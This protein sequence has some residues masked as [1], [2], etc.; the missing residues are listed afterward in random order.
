MAFHVARLKDAREDAERALALYRRLGDRAGESRALSLLGIAHT[1]ESRRLSLQLRSLAISEAIRD[2]YRQSQT[3]NNLSNVYRKLGL[4]RRACHHAEKSVDFD[5]RTGAVASLTY[6]ADSLA[7]AYLGLGNVDMAESLMIEGRDAAQ[8]AGDRPTVAFYDVVLGLVEIARDRAE[9]AERL[10]GEGVCVFRDVGARGLEAA[11]LAWQGAAR[12]ALGDVAGARDL[13]GE[14]VALLEAGFEPVEFQAQEIWWWRYCSL[15]AGD[16]LAGAQARADPPGQMPLLD[17]AWRALDQARQAMLDSVATLSDQG[18][19]RNYFNKVEINRLIIDA[20]LREAAERGLPPSALTDHLAGGTDLQSQM[21]RMLDIGVRINARREAGDLPRYV[22]DE[23]VEL[24]GADRA[25]LVLVGDNGERRLAAGTTA[26]AGILSGILASIPAELPTAEGPDP[27]RLQE[28]VPALDEVAGKRAPFLRHVPTGA[29]RLQQTSVLCVPLIAQGKLVG[30]IYCELVGVHGRFEEQDRDL[31][32]ILANQAAVA[33]ENADWAHTLEQRVQERTAALQAAYE[34]LDQRV[35]ELAL[36]N[37]IQQGLAAQLEAEEIIELVGDKLREIF[38]GQV[39]FVVQYDDEAQTLLCPY[40]VDG[41]GRRIRYE[42]VPLGR[43]LGSIVVQSRE[44]L[45][46]GSNQ[47]ALDLGGIMSEEDA[48]LEAEYQ[49]WIGVPVIVGDAVTGVIGLEDRPENAYDEGD[50]RLLSTL[51]AS[52]GVALENARL[53]DETNQLLEET[54]QRN[55]ELALINTIQQ[56]L[57]AQLEAEEIID[58][59]GDKLREIFPGQAAFVGQYDDA[60]KVLIWPYWVDGQGRRI[61]YEPVALGRG[62]GSI[63]VQSREPLIVGSIEEVIQL[64]GIMSEEDAAL[65]AEY[66]SW[67]GVPVIVGDAVTGVIGLEDRPENAYDEGDARLL[68]TLAASM[69]V[70]LENAR[71]FGETNQLLEETRQR[72]AEL[73]LI[74]TIQKGLAAQLDSE[75]IIHLVGDTLSEVFEGQA[76]IVVQ[77]DEA[78]E[79]FG[80]AYWVEK[81]GRKFRHEPFDLGSSLVSV[82]VQSRKPLILGSLEEALAL[83]AVID[84]DELE[85]EK[86]FQSWIGVPVIVGDAVIGVIALEDRPQDAYDEGDARLLSTLAASM[87]VA[88]QNARLFDETN[89]LLEETRRRAAELEVINSIGQGLVEQLDFRAIIELVG[90]KI[91]RIFAADATDIW[92]Y[93]SDTQEVRGAYNVEKGVR[94]YPPVMPYGR[95]LTSRVIESRLPVVGGTQ[96]ECIRLGAS[97]MPHPEHPDEEMNQSYL[98]V[99]ILVG[100]DVIGVVDVQSYREHAFDEAAVRLLSTIVANMGVALQNARLF[101]ETNRLLEETRRRASELV[102]VNRISR[103]SASELDQGALIELVGEQIRETFSADIAYV[104]LLERET[105]TIAFPYTY[106]EPIARIPLGAGV[107]SRILHTGEPL[108]INENLTDWTADQGLAHAGVPSLS[109]LGVPILVGSEAI[110]VVSVQSTTEAGRFDDDDVRLLGTIAANVG[111]AIQNSRLYQE[112]RRRAEEMAALAE[113]GSDIASTHELTPVLERVAAKARELLRVRDIA[114]ALL[115]PDGQT[116]A[117]AVALG[118]YADEKKAMTVRMG[119]GISGAVAQS[120]VA[121]IVNYPERDPR[122]VHIPG[123]PDREVDALMAAPLVSR[124]QVI[125]LVIAWRNRSDGLF[126]QADLDFLVSVARQAAIAIESARL[127]VEAERRADQMAAVA[128]LGR[129]ASATLDLGAVL[130]GVAS[131]IHELFEARDTVLRLLDP[132]GETLRTTVALGDYADQ[133]LDDTIQMGAGMTGAIAASGVAEV[134]EDVAS[135][136]RAMHVAGTPEVEEMPDTMMC[137]PLI[138]GSGTVGVLSLYRARAE[139][140]FTQVDL[141]FLVALARQVAIAIENAR[142]F[143]E[144]RRERHYSESIVFHS[145]VAITTADRNGTVLSWNPA[146]QRLFGHTAEEAIGRNLDVMVTTPEL[147]AE[148][149]SITRRTVAGERIHA[150]TQR[151]RKDGTP[152]DVEVYAVPADVHGAG[153]SYVAIYHDITELKRTEE[154]LRQ[155]KAAAEAA[156]QA[157]SAFLATMSH[158]IRTPMNAI[159]GMTSLL[160]DTVLTAEQEEYAETVRTSGDA[161]LTII[162]DILDFSKIEAGR[163]EL[164]SQPFD[165][166]DC[167]ESALGLVAARAAEKGLEIGCL[168]EGG[169]PPAIV[170]DDTRLRQVLVN[171]LSN[172]VKFTEEGEVVVTVSPGED[173]GRLREVHI[174]VRDTGIGIPADRMDRLFKSFSQVDVSTSRRYGGTGLGLA[175]SRRLCELMGGRIWVES[176]A[177]AGEAG[178]PAGGPGSVFHF[179]IRVPEA[180]AIERAYRQ[181][182]QGGLEGRRVLVVDDNATNRR[183]LALQ[184]RGWGM[185]A[186]STGSPGEALEWVRGGQEYAVA[187][188]D[189]QMPGMDGAELSTALRKLASGLPI[190]MVS[191]LGRRETGQ[192]GPEIDAFLVK[193]V[194]ASQLHDALVKI[195]AKSIA[196]AEQ[197]K[198]PPSAFDREMAQRLP[199]RILLAEDNVVNQKLALRLLQRLGYRSDVA[200]NGLETIEALR[201]QTYDVVLMDVQMPEMDGLDA[202][203]MICRDWP[204]ERRPHII[205]MTANVMAED[206]QACLEAGMDDYLAKPI[207]VEELVAAL[208]R[209]GGADQV[210]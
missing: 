27:I 166:R 91:N 138:A 64:G 42:P 143:E 133:F 62:L 68:S 198:P 29:A 81:G 171:L 121:E 113:I 76:A 102:T 8:R 54:R 9:R 33:I 204:E 11:A 111:A 52:M 168:I 7:R 110:G 41:Q 86:E 170:G 155:A 193:P 208:E 191:S 139:G 75:A 162:N 48:A 154:A 128:E 184:V 72:N 118:Q 18:L 187:I 124:G 130:K 210:A 95:G 178:T 24:T 21:T 117:A 114:I 22:L 167:V 148:G 70:A 101:D 144:V 103:A 176:P 69:G 136:P 108:L 197:E 59:V 174:T 132:D 90:N 209:A 200:S 183:I 82:V 17:Q 156:N 195:L 32:S 142:L 47:E 85:L 115:R 55:A 199:L 99:P 57:A 196:P 25:A 46:V 65:E 89:R 53:F 26:G 169:T 149:E 201:R 6:S 51:A 80:S 43:G 61:R 66:Q 151:R 87:G 105:S 150:I 192:G 122:A 129:E 177:P 88:L 153:A 3:R 40:W 37:T 67:I 205:A 146:A 34:S 158:E 179:T 100:G 190:V 58:L 39:A 188:V 141:D 180:P 78:T 163:I 98:G 2:S 14:A 172:A 131:R 123:T 96:A 120:G 175:I 60:A 145:P 165:V 16:V 30:F 182:V 160:L 186:D 207:R 56:G 77:Y 116:L 157:K 50:A 71:L 97:L 203:R 135:D 84:E 152:V 109:Y 23:A 4:Y 147:R 63:V 181:P 119:Q 28:I 74:N 125:G 112:A 79:R 44:P 206:R 159:I 164:E 93:D 92:L 19:R 126:G 12:H 202:T 31:L 127:Y 10:F 94:L 189:R 137:A 49:S 36:I 83:G 140:A 5:R 1:D 13:T 106:G 173:D 104:A 35:S 194:R 134:V 73:A 185:E 161:L 45:I 20:W 15:V 38:R 107:T